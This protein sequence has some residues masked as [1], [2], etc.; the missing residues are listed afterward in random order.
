MLALRWLALALPALWTVPAPAQAP[1]D[2]VI[3]GGH[4]AD[5]TG[6][7]AFAADVAV[8]G[9]RI[10]AI[11]D[12][13]GAAAAAEIDARG[14]WI[15]PGFVDVH[16]HVDAE[17]ARRPTA[18]NFV[19]MGV[20]TLITGNCGSSVRDLDAHLGRVERGGVSLNY[21]SL[22]GHGTVRQQVLGTENRA[23]TAA[24]LQ[25]MEQLVDEAMRAGAFGM[26]TGLIYVPGTFAATE[27]LVALARVVSRHGGLYASHMRNEGD[28]VLASI[29][30]ALRIGQ[31]A[32]V[33][34]HLS[35]LKASGRKNWG[36][37]AEI[38]ATLRSARAEGARLSA[39][40]YAYDA[41]STGL[42]VLFP[43][44]ALDAGREGFAKR[45]AEDA[46]FRKAMHAALREKME[47]TGFGDFAWCRIAAAPDKP[48]LNGL[49]LAEAAAK[50]LGSDD[51][52]AQAGLA[53]QLMIDAGARRVS[54]VYHSMSADD[55]ATILAEDWIAVAADA[56]LR[57]PT[58]P[59]RPHPRGSGNNP[60][61]L[62][63]YARDQGVLTME[64]AVRKMTALPCEAFGIPDR[65]AV[66]PGAHADL[67]LFDPGT[68]QDEAT[69]TAPTE[70]P[71]GI[72]WV[73][74]NGVVV[75]AQGR[76]TGSKPGH[77]LR[78]RSPETVR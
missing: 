6:A 62:G 8:R 11:G 7:R 17:I 74:V 73:L 2:L 27:E 13:A 15:A 25:R 66:R 55:V 39:D 75:V 20:T 60:R 47:A 32:S 3:R 56:G 63:R 21:G 22:V 61:V 45:L 76:H 50:T 65:G 9:G 43:S 34:V 52:D 46:A 1:F 26:S 35:H 4:V 67:V 77:V 18:D 54:M 24:E 29:A 68:V 30:E 5:G 49:T 53:I 44:A 36:R 42:E 78:R 48:G 59:D 38:V 69:F 33:R 19:R 71:R 37:G 57:D 70:P 12:L 10:A 72:P 16:A 51:L 23:P 28:E 31:E 64:L 40:Q 41:S 58:S 14:L